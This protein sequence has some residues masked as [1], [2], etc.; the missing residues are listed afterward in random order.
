MELLRRLLKPL[1]V[2]VAQ[3]RLRLRMPLV[4]G[5]LEQLKRSPDVG[6]DDP[7]WLAFLVA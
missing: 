3:S 5:L 4:G 2:A 6:R 7:V 1:Q